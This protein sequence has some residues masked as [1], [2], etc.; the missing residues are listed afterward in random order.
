MKK[1]LAIGAVVLTVAVAAAIFVFPTLAHGTTSGTNTQAFNNHYTSQDLFKLEHIYGSGTTSNNGVND[2]Q[3]SA[4]SFSCAGYGA[5]QGH[6]VVSVTESIINDADSGEAGNYWAYDTVRR[7]I[8]IWSVGTDQY[9][10]LVNYYDSSFQAVAGQRS[11]GN[12][13]TLTGDEYGSFAGSAVFTITGTLDVSDPAAWPQFGVV[14]HGA[15]IDYQCDLAGNCPGYVLFLDKYFT[16]GYTFD[17]PAW[18]WTYVGRDHGHNPP[19][20]A[21]TWVNASTGDSGD[22]LD[23]DD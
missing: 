3:H 11:P 2:G 23:S 17:E 14:N 22:I 5:S 21:G 18:G 6:R 7:S 8:T 19:S 16:A 4:F 1:L 12:G 20:S 10:A 9:C 15:A 13:G